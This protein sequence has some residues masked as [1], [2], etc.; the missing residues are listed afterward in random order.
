LKAL[1]VRLAVDDFGTGYA[2]LGYLQNFPLDTLKIDRSFV[3]D[4]GDADGDTAIVEGVIAMAHGLG[5]LTVAEGVETAAQAG[6]LR[7][8]GCD[9]G[10]G[11]HF[12]RAVSPR[13]ATRLLQQGRQ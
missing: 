1:G 9:L 10:Q 13:A 8:L 12:A 7:A 2:G 4:L 5:M 6:R 3:A 11:W